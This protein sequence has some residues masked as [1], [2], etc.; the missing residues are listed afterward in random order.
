MSKKG[1][2]RVIH[3]QCGGFNKMTL[4]LLMDNTHVHLSFQDGGGEDVTDTSF[5]IAAHPV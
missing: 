1:N 5:F 3:H 4:H 2:V